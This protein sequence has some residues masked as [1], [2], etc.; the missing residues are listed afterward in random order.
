MFINFLNIIPINSKNVD[1][2]QIKN[3]QY[4]I[5]EI[6]CIDN[7]NNKTIIA[8]GIVNSGVLLQGECYLLGPDANGEFK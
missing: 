3:V 7:M 6:I 1:C 5:L 4:D 2:N 8:A